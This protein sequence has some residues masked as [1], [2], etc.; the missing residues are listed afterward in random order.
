MHTLLSGEKF[1]HMVLNIIGYQGGMSS[2]LD[3][4]LA[5]M[6][7]HTSDAQL[8]K[9]F[10]AQKPAP[11]DE[12]ERPRREPHPLSPMAEI[13]AAVTNARRGKP[14][15]WSLWRE[16]AV[17]LALQLLDSALSK[18]GAFIEA[19]SVKVRV[20]VLCCVVGCCVVACCG[21]L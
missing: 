1:F 19:V 10:K 8:D 5:A 2:L 21:V 16:R 9:Y 4:R 18:D 20:G 6:G 15:D 3:A 13:D 7:R 17:L 11:A 12:V 14:N